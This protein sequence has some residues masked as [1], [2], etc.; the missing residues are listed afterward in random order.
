MPQFPYCKLG[1]RVPL[2]VCQGAHFATLGL[3]GE[4]VF[5]VVSA[6]QHSDIYSRVAS[7]CIEASQ[8]KEAKLTFPQVQSW[9]ASDGKTTLSSWPGGSSVTGVEVVLTPCSR[10]CTDS[11]ARCTTVGYWTILSAARLAGHQLL[12]QGWA[13]PRWQE[14][15]FRQHWKSKRRLTLNC[16]GQMR[17]HGVTDEN[18]DLASLMLAGSDSTCPLWTNWTRCVG[19]CVI[20][21][22]VVL[23]GFTNL[24]YFAWNC[25]LPDLPWVATCFFQIKVWIQNPIHL[26]FTSKIECKIELQEVGFLCTYIAFTNA[27]I[28]N[29]AFRLIPNTDAWA[30]IPTKPTSNWFLGERGRAFLLLD[31]CSLF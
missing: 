1:T 28:L 2:S 15:M 4:D 26:D 5:W 13:R 31:P 16:E 14:G 29:W 17:N 22:S 3:W 6:L 12:V 23:H 20:Y 24:A 18:L 8:K 7:L 30:Q 19:T 25:S 9:P 11:L 21:L 10:E 27:P